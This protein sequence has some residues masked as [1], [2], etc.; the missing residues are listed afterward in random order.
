M[1]TPKLPEP[2]RARIFDGMTKVY[3]EVQLVSY[4]A[5]CVAAERERCAKVCEDLYGPK[6]WS[7]GSDLMD[8][9]A[10]AIRAG[11]DK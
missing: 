3:T 5:K 1:T 4:A 10:T 2:M 11:A 6:D 8:Q 9:C 7:I